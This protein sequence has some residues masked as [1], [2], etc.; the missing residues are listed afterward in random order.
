MQTIQSKQAA[1]ETGAV[2]QEVDKVV[3]QLRLHVSTFSQATH[4]WQKC[5]A[6]PYK[7]NCKGINRHSFHACIHVQ[8]LDWQT[9][10]TIC[11][12]KM[13]ST[14][15]YKMLQVLSGCSEHKARPTFHARRP[16]LSYLS[17]PLS[18][19]HAEHFTGTDNQYAQQSQP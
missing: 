3:Q 8:T 14:L 9:M 7:H 18:D 10:V 1:G 16:A 2:Q 6:L 19:C 5:S 11:H 12:C 4:V 13:S 17:S 15:C